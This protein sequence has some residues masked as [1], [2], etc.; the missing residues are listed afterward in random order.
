MHALASS[1][2][3]ASKLFLAGLFLLVATQARAQVDP[4]WDH[5]RVY[6]AL[7]T[8]SFVSPALVLSDQFGTW[9]YPTG[10]VEYLSL[11]AN[12]DQ[13]EHAGV[14]FPINS[15]RLHYTWWYLGVVAFARP[16]VEVE[17][18]FGSQTLDFLTGDQYLLNPAV[19]NENGSIPIANHYK[20]Y[21]VDG[22]PPNADVI[23]EDQFYQ[24]T[25]QVQEPR[26]LCNPVMK[27]IVGGQSY[28]IV[29]DDQHLVCYKIVAGT[30]Q[31]FP[32]TVTDQ[33]LHEVVL[34]MNNDFYLCVPSLKH[35]PT[36]AENRTWGRVKVQY[37]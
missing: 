24:R 7:P 23:L 28:P 16:P 9:T 32:A 26:F 14:V 5:Y 27:T 20:C 22:T 31:V 17:N 29:N 18:Q 25:A 2:R 13:K 34:N 10:A 19:K 21:A 30:G 35:D 4:T 11:F 33:F 12:P 3:P 8:P 15:P 1:F 36:Q 6:R 37:R